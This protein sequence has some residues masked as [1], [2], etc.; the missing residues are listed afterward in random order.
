MHKIYT[1]LLGESSDKGKVLFEGE[2]ADTNLMEMERSQAH[3]HHL[4]Y[5]N[6]GI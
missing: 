5:L 3:S 1:E 6:R 2:G 4:C